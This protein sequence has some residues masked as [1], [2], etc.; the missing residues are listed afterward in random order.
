MLL[1]GHHDLSGAKMDAFLLTGH[2]LTPP[3]TFYLLIL[4]PSWWMVLLV[5]PNKHTVLYHGVPLY[6]WTTGAYCTRPGE[7]KCVYSRPS[8]CPKFYTNR[9]LGEQNLRQ[10]VLKFC[11]N[12]N[13]NRITYLIKLTLTLQ[14]SI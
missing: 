14:F 6:C 11:S 1:S 13:S 10:K 5:W 9:I 2:L 7:K 3:V 12:L 8:K 4:G